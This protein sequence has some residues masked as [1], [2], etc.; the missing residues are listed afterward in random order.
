MKKRL[1]LKK[2]NLKSLRKLR[3]LRKVEVNAL[4]I[5]K[6]EKRVFVSRSSKMHKRRLLKLKPKLRKLKRRL[7]KL[8]RKSKRSLKK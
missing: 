5:S 4:R 6:M 3:I 2:K 7:R 1:R 8:K